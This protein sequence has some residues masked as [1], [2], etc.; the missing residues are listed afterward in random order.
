MSQSEKAPERATSDSA[1]ASGAPLDVRRIRVVLGRSPHSSA[2]PGEFLD[3][4]ARLGRIER[5][6]G[7][8]LIHAA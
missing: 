4:L 7:G 8:D 2:L 1:A 3:R 5:Y 6:K